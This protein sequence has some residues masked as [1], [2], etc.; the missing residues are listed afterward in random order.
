MTAHPLTTAPATHA[1][2]RP[3]L[4]R[5]S[6]DRLFWRQEG[7]RHW[8]LWVNGLALW[9]WLFLVPG[10]T[11]EESQVL[12]W[13]ILWTGVLA[14]VL[15][16]DDLRRGIDPLVR[17]LPLDPARRWQFHTLTVLAGGSLFY[18]AGCIASSERWAW[19][20]WHHVASGPFS[21]L[22]TTT[23]PSPFEP[24]QGLCVLALVAL[25][26]C[27]AA[28]HFH[29]MIMGLVYAGGVWLASY[30]CAG[31]YPPLLS[32]WDRSGGIRPPNG[33][34]YLNR[35]M[36]AG[37]ICLVLAG[38]AWTIGTLHAARRPPIHTSGQSVSLV[39]VAVALAG[40]LAV[41]QLL[42]VTF[43]Q[44]GAGV[45]PFLTTS[46]TSI[47]VFDADRFRANSPL[48][49]WTGLA[50]L[51]AGF[52]V[53]WM[54]VR[55]RARRQGETVAA[56]GWKHQWWLWLA[57]T[58]ALGHLFAQPVLALRAKSPD[59][60]RPWLHHLDFPQVTST[61]SWDEAYNRPSYTSIPAG[62]DACVWAAYPDEPFKPIALQTGTLPIPSVQQSTSHLNL[63]FPPT[64]L[65]PRPVVAR[66]ELY[67]SIAAPTPEPGAT[68][69]S[70]LQLSIRNP[71]SDPHFE[72]LTRRY[73]PLPANYA[74]GHF[75]PIKVS[76][77][78][79]GGAGS[80]VM[81]SLTLVPQRPDRPPTQRAWGDVIGVHSR[82]LNMYEA[83]PPR[84]RFSQPGIR[85]L[86]ALLFLHPSCPPFLLL[87]P[88]TLLSGLLLRHSRLGGAWVLVICTALLLALPWADRHRIESELRISR[89]PAYPEYQRDLAR[90][91]AS[92]SFFHQQPDQPDR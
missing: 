41:L 85:G 71:E 31:E 16:G 68:L 50:W 74:E 55:L 18:L 10:E 9:I 53:A 69:S 36:T 22:A 51:Q 43:L 8:P 90:A 79:V 76:A 14:L 12:R 17:G 15:A 59:L 34:E 75:M 4:T 78:D 46:M 47:T 3:P 70:D 23:E 38:F 33:F 88:L 72:W 82:G 54:L 11:T 84:S 66:L 44:Q 87:M 28:A 30:G 37:L 42:L 13:S 63:T 77:F 86:L 89:N 62:Y 65:W 21:G 20:L 6:A 58:I 60:D 61:Q 80:R 56:S 1:V 39:S 49:W 67:R 35:A 19:H 57:G 48:S 83:S 81:W 40:G 64:S 45:I 24:W 32:E 2:R 27:L 91:K 5:A 26:C 7:A 29:G 92:I 25:L 73:F 52:F